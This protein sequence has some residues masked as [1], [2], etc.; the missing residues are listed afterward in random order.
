MK[1]NKYFDILRFR[2]LTQY[3]MLWF[4]IIVAI[5]R[6]FML[7]LK[8]NSK[9]KTT[10]FFHSKKCSIQMKIHWNWKSIELWL[11]TIPSRNIMKIYKSKS[12]EKNQRQIRRQEQLT[13]ER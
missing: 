7:L 2:F 11:G 9:H 8:S 5:I 3:I 12:K 4:F 13:Y 1:V 6:F 10:I